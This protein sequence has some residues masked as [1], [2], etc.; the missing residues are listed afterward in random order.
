MVRERGIMR[1]VGAIVVERGG[2]MTEPGTTVKGRGEEG[3]FR[4]FG[5]EV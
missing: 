1:A 5:M 2:K 3:R 4:A